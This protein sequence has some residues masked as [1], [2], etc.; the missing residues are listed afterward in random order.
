MKRM[1]KGVIYTLFCI[2][3]LLFAQT[4]MAQ[5][6]RTISG[7][8]LD[9]S[10][11]PMI[12]ATVVVVGNTSVGTTTDM[13]G[14]FKIKA[15][16]DDQLSFSFLGYVEVT[17]RVGNRTA[18]NIVMQQENVN[19]NEVV[20]I[21]YG[22]QQKSDLTG[23]I[24]SINMSDLSDTAS[25]SVDEA[26]QGRISGVEI[27]STSGEP[28][29]TSEIRIR[30][31]RSV[32][33][34]NEPLIVVDGVVD[35]VKSF[36]DL[37]PT[38][39]KNVTVLKDASSTAIYGARGSN[40][41]I[42]VTTHEAKA[43]KVNITFKAT[44]SLSEL[45]RDLDMMNATEF[46]MYRND[47][48]VNSSY[49]WRSP[50]SDK[51]IYANPESLGV[52]TEWTDILLR[53]AFSQNYFL[54]LSGG[55][56]STKVLFSLSYRDTQGIVIGTDN[57]VFTGRLKIDHTLFK[58]LSLGINTN[59]TFQ[60]RN[61]VKT[62]VS[63]TN[64][65]AATN[66]SPFLKPTDSWDP[67]VSNGGSVY[68]S[69]Y[70]IAKH[71]TDE[72]GQTRLTLSPYVRLNLAKGLI[73]KSQFS[74][75]KRIDDRF[76]Y[77]PSTMPVARRH[78]TGGSATRDMDNSKVLNTSTTLTYNKTVKKAH[79]IN[80]VLGF[81]SHDRTSNNFSISGKGYLDDK[82]AANNMAA[83]VD[84]RNLT[85]STT[86][87]FARDL[88]V[89][90][91]VN[92]AYKGRYHF[93]A[94][95]R[96]DGSS[97]FAEGHKWALF[98]SAAFRWNI[99]KEKF[100]RNT[101]SW[102]S[103]LSLRVSAGRTGNNSISLY[104]SQNVLS[105]TH[106]GWLFGDIMEVGYSPSHL[107]SPNLTWEKTNSYNLG[108]DVSFLKDR[109]TFEFEAYMSQTKDLLHS[110]PNAA[111]TGFTSRLENIGDTENRGV[112]LTITSRNITRRNF[113]W[114]TTV[115]ASHNES[116]VTRLVTTKGYLS[117]YTRNGI[118]LYGL[119][120]GYPI[121][122]LWGL[123]YEGVWHTYE[124]LRQE[125]YTKTYVGYKKSPGYAR[126]LDVNHDGLLNTKDVIYLGSADPII[127]GGIRNTFVIGKYLKAGIFF[128]YSVGGRMYNVIEFRTMNGSSASNQDR[129]MLDA[130]HSSRN[131][132]SDIPGATLGDS[133][134]SD[135]QIYDASYLRLQN[136]NLSYTL[137]LKKKTRYVRD[138][139]F[140][141]AVSNVALFSKFPGY[142]PDARSGG[143]RIDTGS[144]PKNRT[145]SLAIEIRY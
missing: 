122:S 26:L 11:Q 39:I 114:T 19:I 33:A 103:D 43:N 145:Y 112:E 108:L 64:Q 7:Q 59:Y 16:P 51:Y 86:S 80:A 136:I 4:A 116:M 47:A 68:N 10:G 24:S 42:L 94:S 139:K 128:T 92:Y 20:V 85:V 31:T 34:S 106:G 17:E 143:R 84:E 121:N 21:G 28:G 49:K 125:D 40:G 57:N 113:K 27:N 111:V 87:S 30:G 138:I 101:K 23:A 5:R 83:L 73:L 81:T 13:E 88:S 82:V 75:V 60:T 133:W 54:S 100:M 93:T 107:A 132:F 12:G 52:G 6:G 127:Y 115:T 70:L 137:D 134:S 135:R 71:V 41:V 25:Q 29:A 45:A 35:A 56:K 9:S 77:S 120:E 131:P 8:V 72:N 61:R 91:R 66:M 14:K 79:R 15:T 62:T 69:P 144:Y 102:L 22:T 105:A 130:W 53:K 48:R 109:I 50:S 2:V 123:Q 55:T 44:F 74:Y 65:Y 96:G 126:Y 117:T 124:E 63:G 89:F 142:D 95:A 67:L 104:K 141:A 98:P 37:D 32:E 97:Y 36:S 18:I 1:V 90:A 38:E 110:A 140:T 76:Y 3:A 118:M 119:K 99:S 58:W 78:R 46:A 129:R